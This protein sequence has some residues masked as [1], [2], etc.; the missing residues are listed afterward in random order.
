MWCLHGARPLPGSSH[1]T[2]SQCPP[3]WGQ[4]RAELAAGL[5][6]R[7]KE[8]LGGGDCSTCCTLNTYLTSGAVRQDAGDLRR[9]GLLPCHRH[10]PASLRQ[11]GHVLWPQAS[12]QVSVPPPSTAPTPSSP[13]PAPSVTTVP[14]GSPS[15]CS[16]R[17]VGWDRERLALLL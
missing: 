13:S 1:G 16:Q 9:H 6:A 3:S 7:L 10:S 8:L 15:L 5:E 17:G 14:Q 4:L 11:L 2:C 12:P